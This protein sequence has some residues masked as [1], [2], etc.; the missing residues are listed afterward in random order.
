[1]KIEEERKRATRMKEGTRKGEAKKMK[2]WEK[3]IRKKAKEQRN[4]GKVKTKLRQVTKDARCP[5]RIHRDVR[6][7]AEVDSLLIKCAD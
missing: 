2:D 3:K 5:L 1:M 4:R 6:H 7:M